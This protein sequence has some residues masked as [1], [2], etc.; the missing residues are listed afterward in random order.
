MLSSPSW[1]TDIPNVIMSTLVVPTAIPTNVIVTVS[2]IREP[3]NTAHVKVKINTVA[4]T[5][6]ATDA[7]RSGMLDN[8]ETDNEPMV[9]PI[10]KTNDRYPMYRG[11]IA[12][13]SCK[14]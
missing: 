5:I 14:K 3:T 2:H 11:E 12:C 9:Q 4:A 13:I 10:E 6:P 8:P 7:A 1:A